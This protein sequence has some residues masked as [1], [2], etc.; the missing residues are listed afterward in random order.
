MH[1]SF[2]H[3]HFSVKPGLYESSRQEEMKQLNNSNFNSYCWSWELK[4]A[5]VAESLPRW[6]STI[7]LGLKVSLTL[8]YLRAARAERARVL[9]AAAPN[10][11]LEKGQGIPQ[12]FWA[13]NSYSS[14][15][16]FAPWAEHANHDVLLQH[17]EASQ[18]TFQTCIFSVLTGNTTFKWLLFTHQPVKL[19]TCYDP[20]QSHGFG[21]AAPHLW[22]SFSCHWCSRWR[23][24]L[25]R[26][27]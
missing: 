9:Q 15:S 23:N 22:M 27:F 5:P 17:F 20:D 21:E 16:W 24:C 12:C 3:S 1:N 25:Y 13:F 6:S 26:Q 8:Q 2:S 18:A 14:K 19:R 11:L 7:I 10:S 4:A